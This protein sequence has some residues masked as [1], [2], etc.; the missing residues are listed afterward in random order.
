[1][2]S[3]ETTLDGPST[4]PSPSPRDVVGRHLATATVAFDAAT[5]GHPLCRIGDGPDVM[6]PKF[7]E[8]G[9]AA[10]TEL[11]R[12]MSRS[13]AADQVEIASET[14]AAWEN[15]RRVCDDHGGAR[16]AYLNGGVAQ[17]RNIV[18]ELGGLRSPL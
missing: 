2:R 6:R 14:L 8:G 3:L 7:A 1:V 10:V 15:E 4:S 13:P 5:C 11:D 18:A 9:L 16:V 17:L 12:S